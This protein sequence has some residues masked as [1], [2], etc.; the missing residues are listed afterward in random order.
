MQPVPA[1][2]TV[3]VS[4]LLA[5]SITSSLQNDQLILKNYLILRNHTTIIPPLDGTMFLLC[6]CALTPEKFLYTPIMLDLARDLFTVSVCFELTCFSTYTFLGSTRHC[7]FT[8][9]ACGFPATVPCTNRWNVPFLGKLNTSL[10][11]NPGHSSSPSLLMDF[12]SKDA[13]G[14]LTHYM[15]QCGPNQILPPGWCGTCHMAK[16]MPGVVLT[17]TLRYHHTDYSHCFFPGSHHR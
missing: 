8:S 10:L 17:D 7:N 4:V 5:F 15:W 9:V 13:Y 6:P 11:C 3:T 12:L 16:L 14:Q 2:L 1:N